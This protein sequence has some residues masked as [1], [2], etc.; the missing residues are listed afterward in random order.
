MSILALLKH[1]T[2]AFLSQSHKAKIC[3][4][5]ESSCL[6]IMCSNMCNLTKQ[7]H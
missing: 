5:M 2:L 3:K 7:R 6:V 4:Q 1:F